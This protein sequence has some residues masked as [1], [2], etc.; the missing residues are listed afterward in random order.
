MGRTNIDIDDKL[1]EVVMTRYGIHTKTEAVDAALR[2]L[3]GQ[4]MSIDEILE[5]RGA[6]LVE[7]VA[8]DPPP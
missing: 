4:P 2:H 1:L 7:D 8:L 6:R 3:A 5:M